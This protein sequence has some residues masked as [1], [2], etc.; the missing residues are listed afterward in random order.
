MKEKFVQY[1]TEHT[2]FAPG[3]HIVIGV[4][5]GADSVCL[6]RLLY[7]IKEEWDLTLSVV[8]VNH[9]IRGKEADEDAC[10]VRELAEQWHLPF[11]LV[12]RDV[13]ALAEE[14]GKTEEEAGRELRYQVFENIR[15]QQGADG[16]AVAHH[17]EDQAETVL[18]QLLRGSG[19]RGLTG[20]APKTGFVLRPLLDMTRKEIEE[21]LEHKKILY[22]KDST[23]E[24]TGYTRN[25]IRKELFPEMEQ[26]LNRQAVRHLAEMAG[27]ARQWREYIDRQAEPVASRI[28]QCEEKGRLFLDIRE[29]LQEEAVIRDEVLRIFL[30]RCVRG[31]KDI[32][33]THYQQIRELLHNGTG[34]QLHLPDKT[35]IERQYDKLYIY[36]N[37]AEERESFYLECEVPSVNIVD[38][39]E[40]NT[41]ITLAL[42]KRTDLPQQI[43]QKDYTKWFDYDKIRSSLVLRTP[44]EG[45]Y[46]IMDKAG[47]RKKLSRYFIDRKI[48]A[49]DRERQL[50]LAEGNKVLWVIPERIGEDYKVTK[51]TKHVLVVTSTAFI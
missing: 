13:P 3:A 12:E 32:T 36:K 31:V 24:D 35:V 9:G 4:S 6:M 29:L 14:Q 43:P 39:G 49:P 51:S 37:R 23:N 7:E 45:D 30:A 10:Y 19:V 26:R 34:K 28:I 48:P 47:H 5:G 11:Y 38:M 1:I 15:R 8:H 46:F 40:D 41:C 42:K 33:R 22:R 27:D 20:M 21:Y 17:Q 16:I 44:Q 50:V 18:F 2:L 25:Y